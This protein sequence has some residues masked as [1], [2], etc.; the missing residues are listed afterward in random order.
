MSKRP[1]VLSFSSLASFCWI[2]DH[3]VIAGLTSIAGSRFDFLSKK[4]NRIISIGADIDE[5]MGILS[6]K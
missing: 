2:I 4:R 3:H 6:S 5:L 1:S